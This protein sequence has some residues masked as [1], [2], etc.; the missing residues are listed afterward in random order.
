MS[1]I[2]VLPPSHR[3]HRPQTSPSFSCLLWGKEIQLCLHIQSSQSITNPKPKATCKYHSILAF[4]APL[5]LSLIQLSLHSN[6]DGVNPNSVANIK[7]N[8]SR[9]PQLPPV[10]A[11]ICL[12]QYSWA[13]FHSSSSDHHNEVITGSEQRSY[14]YEFY[15]IHNGGRT[16]FKSNHWC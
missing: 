11:G 7:I 2:I 13:Y 9:L 6:L 5:I 12:L 15:Q 16:H 3:T 4:V 1:V 14:S 8:A 10:I